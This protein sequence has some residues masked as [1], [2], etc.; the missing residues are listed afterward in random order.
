DVPFFVILSGT[1]E[2]VHPNCAT[3]DLVTVHEAGGF[4]GEIN[5]LSGRASLVRG[6]MREPG[7]LLELHRDT[8]RTLVQTDPELSE[9][10]MRA[11]ILRR[12]GLIANQFGDVVLVGSHHDAGTLRLREFLTR[13][14]HPYSCLDVETDPRIEDLF[15]RF[16]VGVNDV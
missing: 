10:F 13:N 9:L 8:L 5:L 2:V 15:E 6:R 11:F 4:T 1:M 3:E 14:G 12:L 16:H 7:E